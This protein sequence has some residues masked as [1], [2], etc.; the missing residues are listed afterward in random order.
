VTDGFVVI[1]NGGQHAGGYFKVLSLIEQ[2]AQWLD[3]RVLKPRLGPQGAGVRRR[4][5]DEGFEAG[6]R[7]NWWPA[8]TRL[9]IDAAKAHE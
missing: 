2:E 7:P 3:S 6:A 1:S 4:Q 9:W 8:N 5:P